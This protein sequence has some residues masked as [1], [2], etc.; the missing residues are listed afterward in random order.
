MSNQQTVAAFLDGRRISFLNDQGVFKITYLFESQTPYTVAIQVS[1]LLSINVYLPDK[2]INALLPVTLDFVTRCN[3]VIDIGNG[4]YLDPDNSIFG[5]RASCAL[6]PST[7]LDQLLD[8]F[9][10]ATLL[11]WVRILPSLLDVLYMR[12]T[13][14]VATQMLQTQ[15]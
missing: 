15:I 1:D 3:H 6:G 4:V 12:R 7:P 9:Y 8:G 14:E 11:H 5:L 13:P 10:D 2:I